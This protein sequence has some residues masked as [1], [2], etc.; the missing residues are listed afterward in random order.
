MKRSSRRAAFAAVLFC[1]AA[2]AVGAVMFWPHP[3]AEPVPSSPSPEQATA[4]PQ[5][6]VAAVTPAAESGAIEQSHGLVARSGAT[7][8]L[9]MKSGE[10]VVLTNRSQCGDLPCPAGLPTAY[11]YEG[12]DEKVAGYRLQVALGASTQT[13]VLTYGDDDPT[14][15][16]SRHEAANDEPTSLPAKPAVAV[17]TDDSLAGW[18]K[19]LTDE[20]A[21]TEKP[22]LAAIA[23][24]GAH[25]ARDGGRLT[26]T[27]DDKRRLV[28]EDD[29]VC[30]QLACPP[31]ISRSFDFVGDSPDGH[32]HV[33]RQ[34]WNESEL[35]MLIDNSGTVLTMSGLPSFSPDGKFVVSA[36][37]DLEEAQ[38]QRLQVWTLVSGKASSV[39]ALTAKGEDDTVYEL[40]GWT[41][42]NHLR[43]KRGPWG[44]E[45]R[46]PVVL[47][48]DAA[49]WHLEEG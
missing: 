13:M 21:E 6:S 10:V 35:S 15:I 31:Q 16:D 7:L 41:D 29:L 27:L 37:S 42:S 49:G 22:A 9:R 12:W 44:G 3:A 36:V 5:S 18:L 43:L 8:E 23:S 39:F 1:I 17:K 20:R 33:V 4:P 34:Q 48:H 45:Q 46:S 25:V 47:V 11:H 28:F 26:V 2:G 19:D 30:G 38:P 32:F 40:V 24:H 14:L